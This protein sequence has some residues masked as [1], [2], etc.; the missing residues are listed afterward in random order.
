MASRTRVAALL[1]AALLAGSPAAAFA[2]SQGG[3][4]YQ[5]PFGDELP[6]GQATPEGEGESRIVQ[7]EPEEDPE[8]LQGA[9]PG[10][11][12]EQDAEPAEEPEPAQQPPPAAELPDTGADAGLIGFA[13]LGMILCGAGVRLRVRPHGERPA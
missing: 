9:P 10:V 2:Q 12:A 1:A 11:E 5:D 7:T 3:D 4:Q 6:G 13:G 8:P